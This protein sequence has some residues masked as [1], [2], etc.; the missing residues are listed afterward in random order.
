MRAS[1]VAIAL[2]ALPAASCATLAD[3]ATGDRDLP[4]AEAGPFRA[5]RKGELGLSLVA[6]NVIDDDKKL[7]RDA[8]VID[9]DG[10]PSTFEVVA[11]FAAAANGAAVDD[12]PIEIRAT[13][14]AD[15]RSFVKQAETALTA[16]EGWEGGTVG[17]PSALRDGD[18][19]RLYYAASGGIGL[20]VS[21]G[22]GP[23][24]KVAGPV[25]GEAEG[26]WDDGLV[27]RSPSVIATAEGFSLF[28]EVT[29]AT[30]EDV[31]GE[32]ASEDG[33]TWERVGDGPV[34]APGPAGDEAYDD[35]GV[36]APCV[37]AGETALGRPLLRMYYGALTIDEETGEERRTIGLAARFPG[38]PFERGA[39]PVF[40]AGSSRA[41]TEPGVVALEGL[42]FLFVT[43]RRSG[44]SEEPAI[45][46]GVAPAQAVLP[47][48]AT[49]E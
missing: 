4:N 38:E 32:A 8:S 39:S 45:A 16:T 3:A 15:G 20:A 37:I 21:D 46:A 33:V 48:V 1:I 36:F 34:L 27:P 30:G 47:P 14:A 12:P 9:A 6:P 31:I 25:L 17:A 11:F 10:D 19:I 43:Q 49:G 22:G 2:L 42:T 29:L 41:P 26:G 13:T 18:A 24:E 28:Y 23:F 5:L 40:G 44:T 35:A 7:G